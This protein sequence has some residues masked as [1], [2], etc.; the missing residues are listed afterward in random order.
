[1]NAEESLMSRIF[2]TL[3]RKIYYSLVVWLMDRSND[4]H[5]EDFIQRIQNRVEKMH[6]FDDVDVCF[7]YISSYEDENIF[8]I[9]SDIFGKTLVQLIHDIKQ[10]KKIYIYCQNSHAYPIWNSAQFEKLCGIFDDEKLLLVM[11]FENIDQDK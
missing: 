11:L 5:D 7:D 6:V 4:V 1:M 9:V 8:L 2:P 10:I 3:E